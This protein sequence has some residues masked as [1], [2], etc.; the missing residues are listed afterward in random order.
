MMKFEESFKDYLKALE[1]YRSGWIL[2]KLPLEERTIAV[3]PKHI[4]VPGS[5][6]LKTTAYMTQSG[7]DSTEQEEIVE[8]HQNQTEVIEE[9]ALKSWCG[10]G[11]GCEF[12]TFLTKHIP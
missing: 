11:E 4:Q 3:S 8:R 10:H 1:A 12:L 6:G 9:D 5:L 7:K 2:E